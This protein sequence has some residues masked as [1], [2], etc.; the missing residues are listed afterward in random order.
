MDVRKWSNELM[1]DGGGE[2]RGYRRKRVE[3]WVN[4]RKRVG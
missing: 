2:W 4:G 3:K 1:G